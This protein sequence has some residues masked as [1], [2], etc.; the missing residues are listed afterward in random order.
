[1]TELVTGSGAQRSAVNARRARTNSVVEE[2]VDGVALRATTV[3]ARTAGRR[4]R[5][6]DV[7]DALDDAHR[8]RLAEH[9]H[10][11]LILVRREWRPPPPGAR[12]VRA[13]PHRRHAPV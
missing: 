10:P 6:H 3:L 11:H 5:S 13:D 1:M 9:V 7:G 12:K 4:R 8:G 2:S